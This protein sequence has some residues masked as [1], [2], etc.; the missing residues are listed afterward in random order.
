[1]VWG[2]AYVGFIRAAELDDLAN[3]WHLGHMPFPTAWGQAPDGF[4][5]MT[6]YPIAPPDEVGPGE[7]F[8]PLQRIVNDPTN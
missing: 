4:V 7:P 5:Y 1:V 6:S 3:S 2:D 8:S